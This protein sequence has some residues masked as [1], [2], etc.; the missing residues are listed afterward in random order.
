M[1]NTYFLDEFPK[2]YNDGG[3]NSSQFFTRKVFLKKFDVF[4]FNL[5]SDLIAL[6]SIQGNEV[7][8][9]KL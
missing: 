5:K 8:C 9:S 6:N 4:F 1:T 7:R 3:L 2:F